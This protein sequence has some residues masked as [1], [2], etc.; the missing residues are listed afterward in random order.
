MCAAVENN[1][2]GLT[3]FSEPRH[4][5]SKTKTFT[6][7]KI[8][9]HYMSKTKTFTSYKILSVSYWI[10]AMLGT[11]ISPYKH[12]KVFLMLYIWYLNNTRHQFVF[13]TVNRVH[14]GYIWHI[15][16]Y[17]SWELCQL[18]LQ[19]P[20]LQTIYE[21]L[22]KIFYTSALLLIKKWWSVQVSI[23]H[24]SRQLSCRD[25]CKFVTSLDHWRVHK[26]FVICF[27][28]HSAVLTILS[29]TVFIECVVVCQPSS[30]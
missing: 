12:D 22:I 6:S 30:P 20:M 7:Y 23:L 24:M 26:S 1:I 9:R 11:R 18:W 16:S 19:A 13:S 14:C 8:P 28:G 27:P 5:M 10:V 17:L 2:N 21:L 15:V 25:M 4:Y 3:Y 29:L